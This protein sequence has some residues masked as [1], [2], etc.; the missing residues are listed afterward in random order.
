MVCFG[1]AKLLLSRLEQDVFSIA[2]ARRE[3]RPPNFTIIR[4]CTQSFSPV[5]NSAMSL[6]FVFSSVKVTESLEK[7]RSELTKNE[8]FE[9]KVGVCHDLRFLPVG[10]LIEVL[11]LR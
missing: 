4:E 6:T 7:P 9:T 1:R 8:L 5:S 2:S 10:N 11:V 3:P